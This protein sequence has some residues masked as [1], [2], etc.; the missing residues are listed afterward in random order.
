M[1]QKKKHDKDNERKYVKNRHYDVV[2]TVVYFSNF[3]TKAYANI[4]NVHHYAENAN[5]YANV[6]LSAKYFCR[7]INHFLIFIRM[8]R[9]FFF[10]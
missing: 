1:P 10:I 9:T 5:G 2:K 6:H 7:R 4:Q 8:N 3:L